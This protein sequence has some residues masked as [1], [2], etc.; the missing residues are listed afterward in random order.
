MK[1]HALIILISL[2]IISCQS[3]LHNQDKLLVLD[4]GNSKTKMKIEEVERKEKTSLLKL[5]YKKMGSSV[6]SSIF[7]MKAFYDIAKV[8]GREYF[9]NL[10]EWDGKD[11]AHYYI[12]G[13]SNNKKLGIKQF[14]KDFTEKNKYNQKRRFMSVSECEILFGNK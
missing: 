13:F 8:R 11:G 6:G 3:K 12:A 5:T 1:Y 4:S 9:I 2:S 14:G 10:K 7:I